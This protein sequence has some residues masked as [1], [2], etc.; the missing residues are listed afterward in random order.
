MADCILFHCHDTKVQTMENLRLISEQ[1]KL[2]V[3]VVFDCTD[4]EPFKVNGYKAF[5]FSVDDY[6]NS[7]YP[8]VTTEQAADIPTPPRNQKILPIYHNPEYACIWFMKVYPEYQNYWYIEYD[9]MFNG[10]WENFFKLYEMADEDFLG[11]AIMQFPFKF[12]IDPYTK[13][14]PKDIP[15]ENIFRFFGCIARMSRRLLEIL[16]IEYTSGRSGYYELSVATFASLYG[17]KIADLNKYGITY[18]GM[19]VGGLNVYQ[20]W[21]QNFFDSCPNMLFH[22]IR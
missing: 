3:F 1:A 20:N 9:V 7:G 11:V 12:W 22:P 17:L 8:L 4:K 13:Y 2:D 6:Y 18:T 15:N 10:D 19:T 5:N 14:L 16:D 21:S